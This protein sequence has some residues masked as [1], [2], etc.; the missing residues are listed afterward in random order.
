[1]RDYRKLVLVGIIVFGGA[2]A[3]L[4]FCAAAYPLTSVWWTTQTIEPFVFLSAFGLLAV[5]NYFVN[6]QDVL[7]P[8]FLY[9]SLWMAVFALYV[10]CPIDVD[11]ISTETQLLLFASAA[12]FSIGN[13]IG[14]HLPAH[15]HTEGT[16]PLPNSGRTLLACCLLI[17]LPFFVKD[18]VDLAGG[19]G[20][21]LISRARLAM[22]QMV[23]QGKSAYS[24]AITRAA[25]NIAVLSAIAVTVDWE[26]G[27]RRIALFIVV[28]AA[29]FAILTTG[30]PQ[31]VQLGVGI[32]AIWLFRKG[33][34]KFIRTL[35]LA[36]LPTIILA[37]S[38]AAIPLLTK[39][40]AQ[41]SNSGIQFAGT[42]FIEYIVGSV[43]ALDTLIKNPP[44]VSNNYTYY[45]IA[46]TVNGLIGRPTRPLQNWFVSVPFPMNTYTAYRPYLFDYG[47]M[48]P[49][50]F[51]AII[52]TLQGYLYL[53]AR[54]GSPVF[55]F[56]FAVYLSSMAMTIF[57]DLYTGDGIAHHFEIISFC[58]LY[59]GLLRKL[60]FFGE[61]R[62][63][64]LRQNT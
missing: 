39:A 27:N 61:P 40:Q 5:S 32:G 21:E 8:G 18:I 59:F 64:P 45:P 23:L 19:F 24:G 29:T 47:L 11:K 44:N 22:I 36:M 55:I 35:R 6:R 38:L 37:L 20:P 33:H 46:T 57:D 15:P 30:R 42:L 50:C 41:D 7:D 3:P 43:P 25:P 52:G 13:F 58:I 49:L 53:R 48:G 10:F 9:S 62:Y 16:E 26:R 14:G 12:V 54:L 4:L 31:I 2:S 28:L 63:K 34:L 1:V 56:L 17:V 60:S 51:A